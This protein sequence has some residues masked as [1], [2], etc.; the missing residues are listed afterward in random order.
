MSSSAL[1]LN[2]ISTPKAEDK[3]K[4]PTPSFK[5]AHAFKP[6]ALAPGDIS[7]PHELTAFVGLLFNSPDRSLHLI[8]AMLKVET[9]LEQLD[10]K[11]DDM[12]SQILER[13]ASLSRLTYSFHRILNIRYQCHKCRPA[14][15][16]LKQRYRTSSTAILVCHSPRH[17]FRHLVSKGAIV[18]NYEGRRVLFP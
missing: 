11:F 10:S 9:L 18:D 3:N 1:P 12:S 2:V 5:Q 7:S 16:P 6:P 14:W 13:S 15:T 17:R 8:P 4:T